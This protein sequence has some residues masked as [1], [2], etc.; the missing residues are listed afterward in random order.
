MV[1][2]RIRITFLSHVN[3]SRLVCSS[4]L[5]TGKSQYL[6]YFLF[7]IFW[8]YC[9]PSTAIREP[10][11]ELLYRLRVT[12]VRATFVKTVDTLGLGPIDFAPHVRK[13]IRVSVQLQTISGNIVTLSLLFKDSMLYIPDCLLSVQL[14]FW[15]FLCCV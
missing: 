14:S 9:D 6:I 4:H 1:S 3:S 7:D 15:D 8:F 12:E 2:A 11:D 13:H 5:R 10:A